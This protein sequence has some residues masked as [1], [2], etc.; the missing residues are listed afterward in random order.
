MH[1]HIL[2][3]DLFAYYRAREGE[4][5]AKTTAVGMPAAFYYMAGIHTMYILIFHSLVNFLPHYVYT[6]Y[7]ASE[8]DAGYIASI[9]Y[10]VVSV[11]QVR[12]VKYICAC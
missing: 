6:A 2:F 11:Q 10:V 5:E 3:A 9:P 1:N 8:V 4:D 7:G 12:G